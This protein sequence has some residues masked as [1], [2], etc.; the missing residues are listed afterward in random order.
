MSSLPPMRRVHAV[1]EPPRRPLTRDDLAWDVI[2]VLLVLSGQHVFGPTPFRW[3]LA[4]LALWAGVALVRTLW[5]WWKWRAY[6]R[7]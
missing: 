2:V 6:W 4:Y 5:R 7:A 1:Q 3:V